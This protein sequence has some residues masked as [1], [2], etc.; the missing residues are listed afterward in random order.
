MYKYDLHVH[1]KE[2]S[3]CSHVAAADM[4]E[5][6]RDNGYSGV[7]ITDHYRPVFFNTSE[8][9]TWE[10]KVEDFLRGYRNAKY[11]GDKYDMDVLLGI[12]LA[13]NNTKTNDFL[14]YGITEEILMKSKDL[15]NMGFEGLSKFCRENNLL[16]YQAHPLRGYCHLEDIALLDGVE[17]HNGNSRHDS[18]NDEIE[19]IASKN[20]LYMISG[21]DFHEYGDE[22]NGGILTSNRIK[23]NNN[24]IKVLKSKDYTLFRG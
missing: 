17:V 10:E 2:T 11:Q 4:I 1:T 22:N 8:F 13:F 18:H 14:I 23:T 6:Y 16:F 7:V 20:D 15:L 24:L 3:P 5:V 21:S 12:E 9:A 19:V